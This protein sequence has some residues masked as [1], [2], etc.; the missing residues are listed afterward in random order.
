MKFYQ[1]YSLYRLHKVWSAKYST[2]Q[3]KEQKK[4][5]TPNIGVSRTS[6]KTLEPS[7]RYIRRTP[8]ASPPKVCY[9]KLHGKVLLYPEAIFLAKWC[10]IPR[11]NLTKY[12][13]DL[14]T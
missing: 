11:S 7:K 8:L 10:E 1:N 12:L 3:V 4:L 13:S 14:F 6:Q 9:A 5:F 2:A